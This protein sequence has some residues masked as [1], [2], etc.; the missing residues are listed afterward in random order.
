MTLIQ[1]RNIL[2]VLFFFFGGGGRVG[3]S[4]A[5]LFWRSPNFVYVGVFR[6]QRAFELKSHLRLRQLYRL[7]VSASWESLQAILYGLA[8]VFFFFF[9]EG[10]GRKNQ[11]AYGLVT[12][13]LRNA[14]CTQAP[15]RVLTW[16]PSGGCLSNGGLNI[17]VC[18]SSMVPFFGGV[19]GKPTGNPPFWGVQP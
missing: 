16:K 4:E 19:K 11:T 18:L 5:N 8:F 17:C 9:V 13:C 3:G 1:T 2:C 15:N 10:S 14:G 7:V 6:A 12:I